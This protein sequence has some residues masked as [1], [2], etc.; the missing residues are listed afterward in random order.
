M[1]ASENRSPGAGDSV[2]PMGSFLFVSPQRKREVLEDISQGSLPRPLYYLL[3]AFSAGIAAFGLIGNSAAVVI[4][5]MLVSPLMTPIFGISLALSRGDFAL[6]RPALLAEFG[7]VALII[8]FAFLIGIL[9]FSL[10]VTSEMLARTKPTLIDLLVATLAGLAGGLAMIDER[11][12][13]MLPGVAI[14]TSLTP[15][16]ATSGLSLAFGAYDG[17][18]GAFLL[19]FANFLA[20]LVVSAAVFIGAG[21]VT[22][23]QLGTKTDW[24]K[25]FSAAGIGLL[26]V[27]ALLT[28]QLGIMI[29]DWRTRNTIVTTL[30]SQLAHEPG[31]S[32]ASMLYRTV[33]DSEVN[34]LA[35][36]LTPRVLLPQTVKE[37]QDV[38]QAKLGQ[39]VVLFVR[40][41]ITKEVAAAGS[42]ALLPQVDLNGRFVEA[43]VSPEVRIT[44]TAEQILLQLVS[45]TRAFTVRD[46]E[47]L[48]MP[49]GP[50]I[51]ASIEGARAPVPLQVQYAEQQIRDQLGDPTVTLLVRATTTE[52]I[53]AKGRILIGDAHFA[54]LS[55]EQKSVQAALEEMSRTELLRLP[56]T[57]VENVDAAPN[58]DGWLV[59]AETAGTRAPTP[60]DVAAVEK[61]LASLANTPVSLSVWAST[62]LIVT[63]E[64]YDS[65]PG[66]IRQQVL[67]RRAARENAQ[68]P[69]V[70]GEASSPTATPR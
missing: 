25:R 37:I 60:S 43:A 54:A 41:S 36:V 59:R 4:G 49:S 13:P 9:P 26:A 66:F 61:H 29:G 24:V 53:T 15:P 2:L 22:R 33:S 42:V 19:F 40:C 38:L 57:R 51:V 63:K 50:V 67:Q 64:G 35:T 68:G 44:E 3:L 11:T 45:A 69:A 23:Q 1:A 30:E 32:L 12:S 18:W 48:Q 52:D 47:M 70:P 20:I 10:E 62:Q 28:R 21:F 34:V 14:A 39:G 8:A 46:V 65:I 56:D 55:A 31:A 58:G 5:A 27:T 17:A 6:L 16:L 7:G